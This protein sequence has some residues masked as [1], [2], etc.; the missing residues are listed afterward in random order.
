[1]YFHCAG[2]PEICSALRTAV[3]EALDSGG[4]SAV[5]SAARADIDVAATVEGVQQ[6]V[7]QQFGTTFAVRT[8]AIDVSA[9]T[10]RTS[11]AVSMP[12]ASNLSFDPQFGSARI[13]ERARLV[14]A[15]I[16]ERVKAFAK[17]KRGG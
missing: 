17:K 14:A 9:E 6:N 11:E 15:D 5:R 10:T 13:A 3:D 1:V 4:L 2:A 16:V 12:P 8:Y 7:S